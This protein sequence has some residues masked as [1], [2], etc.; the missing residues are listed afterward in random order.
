MTVSPCVSSAIA[1]LIFP[2]PIAC[3]ASASHGA[4]HRFDDFVDVIDI[5]R[6]YVEELKKERDGLMAM[7]DERLRKYD[8][9]KAKVEGAPKVWM[10]NDLCTLSEDVTKHWGGAWLMCH[11]VPVEEEC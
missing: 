5:S 3:S 1:R 8:A 4:G 10:I 11:A 6:A 9:L 2:A 7:Y